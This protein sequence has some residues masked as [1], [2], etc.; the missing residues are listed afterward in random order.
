M[1]R[2][3]SLFLF[4]TLSIESAVAEDVELT[5]VTDLTSGYFIMA[6]SD[7]GTYLSPY[8]IRGNN[9][10]VMSPAESAVICNGAD[11][12]YLLKAEE[13]TYNGELVYRV[14]ISNGLHE[15]FPKGI[16][17][18]AYLNSAGWCFFAGESAPSGRS[19]V[20]GQDGDG[21]GL[22]RITYT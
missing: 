20:Y 19:H 3:L 11:Y 8:W 15:L 1:K 18:A 21:L 14:S 16:G 17:G 2:F 10:N 4:A 5:S 12:Y 7:N 22:W 6:Y 9:Q 13:I